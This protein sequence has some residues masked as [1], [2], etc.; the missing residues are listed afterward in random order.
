MELVRPVKKQRIAAF[1]A[2]SDGPAV[3]SEET[4]ESV[5]DTPVAASTAVEDS[6]KRYG[7]TLAATP[8]FWWFHAGLVV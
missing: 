6:P 3:L 8:C 2:D 7:A 1:V 5:Q 4:I